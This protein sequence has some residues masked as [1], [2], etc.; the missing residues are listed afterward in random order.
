MSAIDDALAANEK[1]AQG[2]TEGHRTASP[3]RR[4]VVVTCMDARIMVDALL[5]LKIGD[6]QVIRNA[7]GVVTEDV[8]RSLLV[9]HYELFTHEFMIINHTNC[10]L[11]AFKG[12]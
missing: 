3:A 12:E 10:G 8:I 5:G 4:L 11:L 2:F 1:Y 7:G 9:S 6:A